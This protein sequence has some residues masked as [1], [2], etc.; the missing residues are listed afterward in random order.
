[1]SDQTKDGT[2][3]RL[4]QDSDFEGQTPKQSIGPDPFK[5][6][7][8]DSTE[9]FPTAED[10][11]SQTNSRTMHD[12]HQ[13]ENR[14]TQ[15]PTMTGARLPFPIPQQ[16][17]SPSR[18][19]KSSNRRYSVQKPVR[20]E[21]RHRQKKQNARAGI[22]VNTN[23]SR[24]HGP[25]PVP[26]AKQQ[27]ALPPLPQQAP[28][29]P[30][31]VDLSDLRAAEASMPSNGSFWSSIF[32][33]TSGGNHSRQNSDTAAKQHKR[34][35]SSVDKRNPQNRNHRPPSLKLRDDLSPNDRPI[36]IGLQVPSMN[37]AAHA[38]S[39][40][41][42]A[43]ATSSIIRSYE[44][45]TPAVEP[46]ETPEIMITPALRPA[47]VSYW[48][49]DTA[50][51]NTPQARR[52]ASSIYSR[53]DDS[54]E[55][56]TYTQ[57]SGAPPMPQIPH[58]V[59]QQ[60]N[61]NR[62]STGTVFDDDDDDTPTQWPW[63][64]KSRITSSQ[65]VFEED[66]SPILTKKQRKESL[67][68]NLHVRTNLAP[69]DNRKST[70]WWNTIVS[71]FISTPRSNGFNTPTKAAKDEKLAPQTMASATPKSDPVDDA[72]EKYWEKKECCPKSPLT[73][74]TIAS[75]AWWES[76]NTIDG[77]P[78]WAEAFPKEKNE[79]D[80]RRHK[81]K[82][83]ESQAGTLPIMLG[84]TLQNEL[85]LQAEAEAAAERQRN[86]KRQDSVVRP[87]SYSPQSPDISPILSR[88]PSRNLKTFNPYPAIPPASRAATP[89]VPMQLQQ[90]TMS[91][92]GQQPPVRGM[93]SRSSSGVPSEAPPRYSMHTPRFRAVYPPGHVSAVQQ[94]PPVPIPRQVAPP[95]PGP[96]SPGLQRAMASTGA[97]AMEEVP[98][99][100]TP[101]PLNVGPKRVINLNSGYPTLP[102]R[103]GNM[104][105]DPVD[106][107]RADVKAKKIEK[108]RRRLEKED[109]AAHKAG[110]LWRGRGCMPK[111]GCFGRG[112]AEG[113]KR[114]RCWF[115]GIV[116]VIILI[117]LVVVLVTQLRPKVTPGVEAP[118]Q[119]VNLTAFPP[120][121]AGVATIA[122]PENS[123]E[124]TGCVYPKTVWSCSLPK[125]L[126]SNNAPNAA[127]Q[128][129]LKWLI[130]WDNS[131]SA[132]ATWQKGEFATAQAVSRVG[133][134][135]GARS[136]LRSI[137]KRISSVPRFS[138]S[139]PVPKVE[140]IA[141]LGET[142]DGVK[143]DPKEGE[144]TPFY[145]SLL[146]AF[147]D[148]NKVP[149][150][151]SE[152]ANLESESEPEPELVNQDT[153]LD[154]RQNANNRTSQFP[155]FSKSIPPPDTLADGTA[156][157]ANLFPPLMRQ[158]P[159][160]LFDRGW[161]TERYAFYS[162]FTRSIF[163]KSTALLNGTTAD[164]GDGEVPDDLNG[165]C[166]KR[167]ARV[168]C[169]WA[170]TR[171][172]VSIWTNR[173]RG[174]QLLGNPTNPDGRSAE[175]L[176]TDFSRPGSFPYPVTIKIDRHGG[177]PEFK[178]VYC[179]DMDVR[180]RMV[181][182]SGRVRP[183]FRAFGGELINA[184]PNVFRDESDPS[185]GGFDGGTSGCGCE[186]TNFRT[187]V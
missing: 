82:N 35:C 186:W 126:Q 99:T 56:G 7:F 66:T 50:S 170:Q 140:E 149:R 110:N 11:R 55:Y 30:R 109:A 48:S 179:Y 89:R 85:G 32:G 20:N 100:P 159:L 166:T 68:N 167:E 86:L 84:D 150:S 51:A 15:W 12:A 137:M 58:S 145:I 31:F 92:Q 73:S 143:S 69:E 37:A 118:S 182:G 161:P 144:E 101:A 138:T 134:P 147:S 52:T 9:A 93:Y 40:V 176:A 2:V 41:T 26:I 142:T 135:V 74:T 33:G 127:D 154:K 98:L 42:A 121:F 49:P 113:R 45:Q 75:D 38:A 158:Q 97:I 16:Q 36:M 77:G 155:D 10:E 120:I 169:S 117:S 141:F 39:P 25:Q 34:N 173:G 108:Q 174:A 81:S 47:D 22:K 67:A 90:A 151:P 19:Q 129:S 163:L 17:Q 61:N 187:I 53:P 14:L 83:S 71:P 183:E 91:S 57:A 88:Q 130:Q 153:Q 125:E 162:Y 178:G 171:V 112:G 132:N 3:L 180:G 184:A 103:T 136:V 1:M 8:D 175:E 60:N 177:R 139:P 133:N 172:A 148:S 72:F 79:S 87:V 78:K 65:T 24:H 63:K 146:D 5:T 64:K 95:S 105:V 96:V 4:P 43:S 13:D 123:V 119:W 115:G 181:E 70:G 59:L 29:G 23:F 62:E 107:E 156:A 104:Y 27:T 111:R 44:T 114:R 160:R 46:P 168:R 116:V 185:L 94:P 122:A 102:A 21:S 164:L 131:T 124:N 128:P 152:L 157:P 106:L 80:I 6:L 54:D 165:G 18:Q 76:R 28:P